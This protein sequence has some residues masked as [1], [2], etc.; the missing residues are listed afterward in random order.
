MMG[1]D[2]FIVD[3]DVTNTKRIGKDSNVSYCF[4]RFN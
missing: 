3:D 4:S 2:W 1:T